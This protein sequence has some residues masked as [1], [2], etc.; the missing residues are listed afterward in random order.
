VWSGPGAA[1]T[2]LL[3][4]IISA[5]RVCVCMFITAVAIW[6]SKQPRM[7]PSK[8]GDAEPVRVCVYYCRT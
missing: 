7:A 4:H 6:P 5:R 8:R 3:F 2:I 1:R